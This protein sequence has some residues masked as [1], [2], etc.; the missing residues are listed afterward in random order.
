MTGLAQTEL[1]RHFYK[2]KSADV[3]FTR[4]ISGVTSTFLNPPT[5]NGKIAT[6]YYIRFSDV[7]LGVEGRGIKERVD[8]RVA[9]ARQ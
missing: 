8:Q 1:E 7:V 2:L 5:T 4:K 3:G 9:N 6:V